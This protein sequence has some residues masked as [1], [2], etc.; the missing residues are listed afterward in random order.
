[1]AQENSSAAQ[2]KRTDR[3]G[4]PSVKGRNN[5]HSEQPQRGATNGGYFLQW[6]VDEFVVMPC[7][8]RNRVD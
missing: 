2:A 6:P 5:H 8:Q 1:L 4:I 7:C 3:T